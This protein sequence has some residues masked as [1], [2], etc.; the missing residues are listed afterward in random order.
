MNLW[1]VMPC[2]LVDG[3][4]QFGELYNLY[5]EDGGEYIPPEVYTALK[6]KDYN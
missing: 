6:L 4:Q 1:V 5:P 2:S 3:Y